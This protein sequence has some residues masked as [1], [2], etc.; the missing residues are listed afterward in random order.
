M[1]KSATEMLR[2]VAQATGKTEEEVL[3]D[4]VNAAGRGEGRAP[5]VQPAPSAAMVPHQ[6]APQ[7]QPMPQQAMMPQPQ[8]MPTPTGHTVQNGSDRAAYLRWLQDE[9]SPSGVFGD[10]GMTPGGIF[11]GQPVATGGYDPAA[12]QRAA[13]QQAAIQQAQPQRPQAYYPQ[14]PQQLPQAQPMVRVMHYTG[15][16]VTV[17]EGPAQGAQLPQLPGMPWY[18]GR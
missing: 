14:Q 2:Q 18:P 13:Q 9:L 6:Q 17:Y 7:P 8:G 11:G 5:M 3:L 10:G 4:L 1:G 15:P 16:S 12:E